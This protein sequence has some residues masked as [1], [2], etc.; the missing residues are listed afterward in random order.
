MI[1]E[2]IT[3]FSPATVANVACGFDMF[4]FA[5]NTPGDEIHIRRSPQAGVKITSIHG[6]AGVL[7]LDP[8][9]NTV[10][11]SVLSLLKHLKMEKLGLEITLKKQMPLGSGLGSSA[12]S[13]AGG[14]F[15]AH[16]LLRSPLT[17]KE[18]IPFAME[19]ER[20]ACGAKHADNVAPALLGGFVLI[21][22]YAPLDVISIPLGLDLFCSIV[23]PHIHVSTERAR[24]ILKPDITLQQH[25]TQSAHAAGLVAGLMLGD[26]QMIQHCLQDVIIEPQRAGLIPGFY[27]IKQAALDAGALGCSISG[28]GPSVFALTHSQ[29]KAESI[30]DVMMKSC[31]KH[32]KHADLYVSA[33]N[34]IGPQ[35]LCK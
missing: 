28:S 22:S 35:V 30:A 5:L 34:K 14:V 18:L 15:A 11:V 27:N 25:V 16:K 23:H 3:V 24:A 7:S 10:G 8:Q 2:E 31:L 17:S 4:G 26:T 12:A 1:L 13:A 20:V 9:K 19:G 21:R 29:S 6:D 33:I 32:H